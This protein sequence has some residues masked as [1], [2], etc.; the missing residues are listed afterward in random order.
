MAK[1]IYPAIFTPEDG[2]YSVR[3]PDIESAVTCG[4]DLADAYEMADDV[5]PLV[6]LDMEERGEA[7]PEPTNPNDVV[8]EPD[9]IVSLVH[10][11]TAAYKAK[12]DNAAVKKTLTIPSWLNQ[13]AQDAGINF[14]G[15]L[16][17][18]LKD[19]LGVG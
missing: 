9:E 1:Y 8:K 4:D 18:A 2:G 19:K 10:A 6:L 11:D 17:E 14:S 12:V 13:K 3:F 16:Q 15:V 7:I 5:L